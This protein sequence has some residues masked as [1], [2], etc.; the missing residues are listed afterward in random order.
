MSLLADVKGLFQKGGYMNLNELLNGV[1]CRCG[2][3][4]ACPIE[5][6]FIGK[7]AV[8]HLSDL[9]AEYDKILLV[10]DKN[11]YAAAGASVVKALPGKQ[12]SLVTFHGD[13]L[14]P[15]EKAIHEV[16]E[17]INGVSLILAIGSGV[18]QDLCKYVSHFQKIPYIVVA[19]APSMDGYASDGA[20]MILKGM[21][22]TVPATLPKAIVG[23]TDILV[24]APMDMIQAGYGDII[25]KYSALNDWRL[26]HIVTGEYFCDYI[27]DTTYEMIERVKG[28]ASRLLERDTDSVQILMESLICVGIMMSFATSSRPASGSEHHLSHFFEIVGLAKNEPYLSHGTDV[29]YSTYVTSKIREALLKSDKPQMLHRPDRDVYT[30][31]MKSIYGKEVGEG[32]IAL[33]SKSGL[34]DS[35]RLTA[36]RESWDKIRSVLADMPSAEEIE[37]ILSAIGLDIHKFYDLYGH[38][39]INDAILYAKDLKNR[40][41]VLWLN[42]DLLEN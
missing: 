15:N 9:C 21:K 37:E 6:V 25:G 4:H 13:T 34:Y 36:Y 23:D 29:A 38:K 20:A 22:E 1:N 10:A 17:H 39:K 12:L 30:E 41:T 19:T 33:Q 2:K 35:D 3:H 16:C 24:N 5:N 27:Y 8:S 14:V 7:G 40:Y 26:A 31:K 42:Y 32:C 11:T 18:I 28:V